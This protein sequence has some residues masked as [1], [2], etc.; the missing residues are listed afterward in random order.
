M[1]DLDKLASKLKKTT[2]E[3]INR[4]E[5]IKKEKEEE[6]KRL[7]ER[8]KIQD[9]LE[10]ASIIERIPDLAEKAAL[11]KLFSVEVMKLESKH[12]NFTS[13]GA[14]CPLEGH[15]KGSAKLVYL[16]CKKANLNPKI[17]SWHDG[18]G[19]DSGYQVTINWS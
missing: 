11:K 17:E 5:I 7:A 18:M 9:E 10:A 2:L 8:Q 16:A 14:S 13:Y 1:K 3:A 19:M 15:L 4:A 6:E 12:Y